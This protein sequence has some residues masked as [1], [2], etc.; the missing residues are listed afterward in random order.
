MT[1]VMMNIKEDG[2]VFFDCINH[3]GD[4][5]VCTGV[6]MLCNVLV[7]ATERAKFSPAA[8]DDGHV[9]ITIDDPPKW[10]RETF[11][12]VLDVFMD[13]ANKFPEYVKIY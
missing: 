10:L 6:T 9:R 12:T 2:D 8:Y 7:V 13:M 5:D 1:K 4:H 3:A 11:M